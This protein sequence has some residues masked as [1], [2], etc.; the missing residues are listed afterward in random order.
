MQV[1][2]FSLSVMYMDSEMSNLYTHIFPFY[3][4]YFA[5]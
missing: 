3:D 2:K 5:L 1:Y 4:F